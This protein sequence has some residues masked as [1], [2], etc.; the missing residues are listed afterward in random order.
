MTTKLKAFL[1]WI[2]LAVFG[3]FLALSV[4]YESIIYLYIASIWPMLLVPLLPDFGS[5]QYIKPRKKQGQVEIL[6]TTGDSALLMLRFHPGYVRWNKKWL[7]FSVAD[8]SAYPTL[9]IPADQTASLSVLQHD[10]KAHA[11][12]KGWVGIRIDNL[13]QRTQHLS[14][15]VNEINR[16]VVRI[17]DIQE[18]LSP[19]VSSTPSQSTSIQA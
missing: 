16:I 12:K 2:G 1:F 18:L 8:V 14:Y 17:E 13:K 5:N 7:Y 15:T 3:L 9:P 10:L 6:R 11:R 4:A 19:G